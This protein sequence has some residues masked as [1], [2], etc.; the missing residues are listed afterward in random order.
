MKASKY[1]GGSK[2]VSFRLPIESLT[3]AT[4]EINAI[5]KKYERV[6]PN[7]NKTTLNTATVQSKTTLANKTQHN[8]QCGCSY[9]D[10]LFR[11]VAGCKNDKGM[12]R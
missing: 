11:R 7:K 6:K 1:I 12:H 4:I 2:I 10:G 9:N 8:Y 5:L 3:I